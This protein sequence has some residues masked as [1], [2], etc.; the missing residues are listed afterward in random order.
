MRRHTASNALSLKRIVLLAGLA[1]VI[2]AGWHTAYAAVYA[3][4]GV[5]TGYDTDIRVWMEDDYDIYPSG[6]NL[7]FYIRAVRD[8]FATVYVVD[9]D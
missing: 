3:P 4:A 2:A 8:C 9:T 6:N 7:V 1:M 5:T